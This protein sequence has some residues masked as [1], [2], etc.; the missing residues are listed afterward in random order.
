MV[1]IND[2]DPGTTSP[3]LGNRS[4]LTRSA[5]WEMVER[6]GR[7]SQAYKDL[8]RQVESNEERAKEQW[9]SIHT[10]LE[11]NAKSLQVVLDALNKYRGGLGL[12]TILITALITVLEVLPS[13]VPWIMA[14]WK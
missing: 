3:P 10:E 11:A 2:L 5:D 1:D 13:A 4:M 9:N 8:A 12:L 7:L 6:L 14:H